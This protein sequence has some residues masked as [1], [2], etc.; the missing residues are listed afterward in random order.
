MAGL[1]SYPGGGIYKVTKHGIVALSETLYLELAQREAQVKVSVLCPGYVNT[2]LPDSGR[3]RPDELQNAPAEEQLGPEDEM[4][5]AAARKVFEEG[6]P[7]RQV[8]DRLFKALTEEKFYILTQPELK[9]MVQLRTEDILQER[10][11][12]NA[13][14]AMGL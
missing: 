13:L 11:P 8:V 12:S 14:A 10:D 3:N 4:R 7:P 2:R 9:P 6:M 1:T 5:L